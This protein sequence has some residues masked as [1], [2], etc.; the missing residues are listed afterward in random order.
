MLR[1]MPGNPALPWLAPHKLGRNI[2]TVA[3]PVRMRAAILLPQQRQGDA[4]APQLP[5]D[6]RPIRPRT[7]AR[8]H[9][10]R[11][12]RKQKALQRPIVEIVGRAPAQPRCV[13]ALE[14]GVHRPVAE[15]HRTRD[16]A[17]AHP[18]LELQT[19]NIADLPRRQSL[20]WHGPLAVGRGPLGRWDCRRTRLPGSST[21]CSR[22]RGPS[23]HDRLESALTMPWNT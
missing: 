3:K 5:V 21:G 17:L 6:G 12:R 10:G 1:L 16:H 9:R 2:T 23:A 22:S 14:V 11:S 15:R 13:G 7:S 18:A 8:R 4:L 19:Q 20:R